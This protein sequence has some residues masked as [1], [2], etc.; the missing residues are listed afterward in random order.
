MLNYKYINQSAAN[1]HLS[2]IDQF[3]EIL[4]HKSIKCEQEIFVRNHCWNMKLCNA[5]YVI[6]DTE[7]KSTLRII[8]VQLIWN[9]PLIAYWWVEIEFFKIA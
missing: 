7:W 5:H 1:S 9:T 4:S 8:L 2:A 6:A 3:T